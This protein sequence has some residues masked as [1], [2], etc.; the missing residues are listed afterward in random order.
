MTPKIRFVVVGLTLLVAAI[1]IVHNVHKHFEGE[2]IYALPGAIV[3]EFPLVL[4]AW[5][6]SIFFAKKGSREKIVCGVYVTLSIIIWWGG[7]S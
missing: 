6:V 3:S 1:N 7:E 5:I 4:I 2:F